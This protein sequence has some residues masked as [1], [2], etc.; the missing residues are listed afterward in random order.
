MNNIVN[1]SENEIVEGVLAEFSQLAKI[2]RPSGYE[3]AVSDY[4]YK[5][6][7]DMGCRVVQDDVN[8]IIADMESTEDC[9]EKP[10]TVLQAHMD[11]VCVAA[12]GVDFNPLTDE[13]KLVREGNLLHA[14]GTSLG[15]DDGM[16]IAVRF[17]WV[18]RFAS[19]VQMDGITIC[20]R[21]CDRATA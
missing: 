8:N 3:K 20:W 15:A 16:G 7:S 2:P 9:Q 5:L 19:D 4:L 6:F 12:E 13:I 17:W 18:L 11:M 10:L 21:G 1:I 14:D